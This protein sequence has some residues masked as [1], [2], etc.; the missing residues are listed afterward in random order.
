MGF[1]DPERWWYNR[2][3][4]K[5]IIKTRRCELSK[6]R[7]VFKWIFLGLIVI[8]IVTWLPTFTYRK[9]VNINPLPSSYVKGVYHSHSVYSDGKGDVAE[10]AAAA[11][12]TGVDFAILTDHGNP[13]RLASMATSWQGDLLLI[14]GSELSLP[15]GH[16][17]A[18]GYRLPDHLFPPEAQ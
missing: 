7:K 12:Q 16:L 11:S 3:P 18:V 6:L 8:L 14:G 10:I 9:E 15:A 17:A 4:G 1:D 2:Y 5:C 13:N